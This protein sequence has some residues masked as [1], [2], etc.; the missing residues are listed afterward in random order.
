[1][2][3]ECNNNK[4]QVT[5]QNAFA[6]T[7]AGSMMAGVIAGYLSHIP[8]NVSTLKLLQ[9]STRY[10]IHLHTC[11]LPRLE[12]ETAARGFHDLTACSL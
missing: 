10:I 9:V 2:P 5:F 8:H 3:A 1:M 4:N 11:T 7:A 12:R 6:R